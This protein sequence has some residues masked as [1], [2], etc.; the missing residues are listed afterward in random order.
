MSLNFEEF[1]TKYKIVDSE[2]TKLE[3]KVIPRIFPTYSSNPKGQTSACIVNYQILRYKPW[4]NNQ[5]NAW[6]DQ[7]PN[8]D[9]FTTL[10]HEFL[11][12]PYAQ[13]HVTDWY[14]KLQAV[15]QNQDE[16]EIQ[17]ENQDQP[18]SHYD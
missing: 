2:L 18:V 1:A 10:W 14:D 5:E 17:P 4:K 13:A 12:T 3:D 9:I 11:Q 16:P 6:G 7:E 8:N 15:I